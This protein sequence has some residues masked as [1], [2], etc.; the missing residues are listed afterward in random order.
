[1]VKEHF[2]GE[3]EENILVI[4]MKGNNKEQEFIIQVKINLKLV[5]GLMEK[6]QNGLI[7]MK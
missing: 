2:F 6:E 3:M 4:G 1:M 7:K 5:N